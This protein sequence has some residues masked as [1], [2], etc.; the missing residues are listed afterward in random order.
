FLRKVMVLILGQIGA[1]II[2]FLL[3]PVVTRLYG[4]ENYG[5]LG[6]FLAIS[7]VLIPAVALSY[8]IAIVLP[9]KT[10]EAIELAILSF[11][12]IIAFSL[13]VGF[14]FL[15][16]YDELKEVTGLNGLI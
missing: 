10:E 1:Q 11:K 14:L 5:K 9:K 16:L 13:A 6:V 15:I 8:P 12:V 3:T 2:A 4:P 7:N